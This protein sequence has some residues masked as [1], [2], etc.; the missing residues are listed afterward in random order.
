MR[1]D[2]EYSNWCI[3][4]YV[5]LHSSWQGQPWDHWEEIMRLVGVH[6]GY[7]I[8]F[9]RFQ[10]RIFTESDIQFLNLRHYSAGIVA[11]FI[12]S[13]ES[14]FLTPSSWWRLTLEQSTISSAVAKLLMPVGQ[15]SLTQQHNL[16]WSWLHFQLLWLL[17]DQ[18]WRIG[19]CFCT[20][21]MGLS[22]FSKFCSWYCFVPLK[23]H[24]VLCYI[25]F[26]VA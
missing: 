15:D 2:L 11:P 8:A 20:L 22:L 4:G 26:F 24:T 7:L 18:C 13:S 6:Q 17:K 25:T 9:K 23:S 12:I 10:L 5:S 14:N 21:V 1:Q 16:Q 3:R 19:S